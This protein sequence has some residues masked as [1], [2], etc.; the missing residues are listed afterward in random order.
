MD[1]WEPQPPRAE[2]DGAVSLK[3]R[4]DGG[5]YLNVAQDGEERC[6]RMSTYNAWRVF[7][8]FATMLGVPIPKRIAKTIF[9]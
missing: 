8:M 1:D 5:F 4:P 3:R 2:G 7:A 6:V 9:L